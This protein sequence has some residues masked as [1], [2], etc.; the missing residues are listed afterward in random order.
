MELHRHRAAESILRSACI[1]LSGYNGTHQ[2]CQARTCVPLSCTVILPA[3]GTTMP[4]WSTTLRRTVRQKVK[5]SLEFVQSSTSYKKR[6]PQSRIAVDK[7]I[8]LLPSYLRFSRIRGTHKRPTDSPR[9]LLQVT[10]PSSHVAR[11]KRLS[12]PKQRLRSES[13]RPLSVTV[14]VVSS[15]IRQATDV[16]GHRTPTGNSTADGEK[17][18]VAHYMPATRAPEVDQDDRSETARRSAGKA[19]RVPKRAHEVY[20]RPAPNCS[21]NSAEAACSWMEKEFP[22]GL[23]K[24]HQEHDP[25]Q[26]VMTEPST[27]FASWRHVSVKSA[28]LQAQMM[29]AKTVLRLPPGSF[30]RSRA[31]HCKR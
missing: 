20:H 10:S 2:I 12:G 8:H 14:S 27:F 4:S 7:A 15:V 5:E 29:K 17:P 23:N 22:R 25:Q 13:P 30:S 18:R 11:T 6:R 9:P 1:P 31:W 24:R 28:G 26:R 16:R 3:K 19:R 21:P